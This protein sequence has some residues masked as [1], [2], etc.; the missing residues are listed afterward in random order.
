MSTTALSC[1]IL[2]IIEVMTL[3]LILI[4]ALEAA[5]V[6]K[7]PLI[8][9]GA[10]AEGPVVMIATGFL[11]K[12]HLLKWVPLVIALI[13]GDLLGDILWYCV[14]RYGA[15]PIM[16]KYGKWLGFTPK[17]FEKLK[18][19]FLNHHTYILLI[20]KITLGFGLAKGVLMA[21]G[22][23]KVPFKKFILLNLIGEMVLVA[24]LLLVG[25]FFGN[26][27]ELI[28]HNYKVIFVILL[29][30]GVI[31]GLITL[32]RKTKRIFLNS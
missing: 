23:S 31:V 22:A 7:Y 9:V 8:S 2:Y 4:H 5:N 15:E 11:L 32:S 12:Q 25:Y 26:V 14:G 24:A 1:L 19:L 27:Y 21:A 3:P 16:R 29:I 6:V 17:M 13:V 10:F 18:G 28:P 20:S 30:A